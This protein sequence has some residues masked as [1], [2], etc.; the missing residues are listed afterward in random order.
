MLRTHLAI[1]LTCFLFT[2]FSGAL[3]LDSLRIP[4]FTS[5]SLW[6]LI[7]FFLDLRQLWPL[8]CGPWN[9]RRR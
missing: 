7:L 9:E 6:A 4:F 5:C 2:L 8:S 3:V 1:F